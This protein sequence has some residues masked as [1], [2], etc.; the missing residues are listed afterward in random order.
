MKVII[1]YKSKTGFTKKYAEIVAI[2][3]G[4]ELIALNAV[5]PQKLSGFDTVVFGGR[6]H[7]GI[8][9][10][11]KKAKKLFAK[12]KARPIVFATGATPAAA[13]SVVAKIWESNFNDEER[14]NIPHFY[15]QSG[16]CYEKMGLFDKLLMKLA[17]KMMSGKKQLSDEEAGFARAI[18]SSYDD[19]SPDYAQPL[20][21]FIVGTSKNSFTNLA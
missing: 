6:V 20:I 18:T 17:A 8:I 13:E 12:C 7:A 16:L 15:M 1:I 4:G 14:Q 10:G 5:T 11:I 3:V 19:S 9:D 21:D 2:A